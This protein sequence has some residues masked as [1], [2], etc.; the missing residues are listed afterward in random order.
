MAIKQVDLLKLSALYGEGLNREFSSTQHV[1]KIPKPR[2]FIIHNIWDF[3]MVQGLIVMLSFAGIDAFYDWDDGYATDATYETSE[4]NLIKRVSAAR[5]CMLLA[6][7][8]SVCAPL[9]ITA[10][11]YATLIHRKTYLVLTEAEGQTYG[12]EFIGVH[13]QLDVLTSKRYN[14]NYVVR[15]LEN[16]R[17]NFW[18]NLH[19]ISGL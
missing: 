15:I 16:D 12:E 13:P 10:L 4:D 11:E 17:S 6:T 14:R 19:N 5:A 8:K 7:K 3:R 2:I 18:K 1:M 9:S